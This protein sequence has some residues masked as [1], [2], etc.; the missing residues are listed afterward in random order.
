MIL[1]KLKKT[2]IPPRVQKSIGKKIKRLEIVSFYGRIKKKIFVLC[3]CSCGV[4]NKIV[5]F[6]HLAYN[7]V[8]SCGCYRLEW[9][10]RNRKNYVN[11]NINNN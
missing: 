11:K 4:K 1:S 8:S 3:N 9:L 6:D 5:D 7:S 2:P 10:K